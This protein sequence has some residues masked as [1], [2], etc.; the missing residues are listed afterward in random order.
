MEFTEG[1]KL[2]S[3]ITG[4]TFKIIYVDYRNNNSI[5]IWL[6]ILNSNLFALIEQKDLNNLIDKG[7][8]EVL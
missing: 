7:N 8:M 6:K 3:K 2:K 4:K 5:I 1:T